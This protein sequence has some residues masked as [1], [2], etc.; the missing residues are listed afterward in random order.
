LHAW[1]K[2]AREPNF[3]LRELSTDA[4]I[5]VQYPAALYQSVADAVRERTTMLMVSGDIL[6]DR[7]SRQPIDMKAERIE[8]LRMLSSA[9][10]EEFFGSAPKFESDEALE[11][12][13]NG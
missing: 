7:A 4:L 8:K 12:Y 9:E 2:E 1:F 5:R 3:Q 10:F 13:T 11:T 6:F